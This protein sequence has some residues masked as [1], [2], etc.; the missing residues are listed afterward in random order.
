MEVKPGYKQ[1]EL[2]VIPVDW[3]AVPMQTITTHIGDGLHGTPV[4]SSHG[5]YFFIN[6]NN[7]NAGKIVI[8]GDTQSV[9][10]SEFMK[11]RKP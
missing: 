8:S 3:D 7:L 10:H 6:G 1:S 9:D 11:H 4:Y 5:D 2:G